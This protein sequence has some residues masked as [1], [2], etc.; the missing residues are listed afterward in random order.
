[1]CTLLPAL[2]SSSYTCM[3]ETT[4][5]V[6]KKFVLPVV[7]HN[8]AKPPLFNVS[9]RFSSL[10]V[11]TPAILHWK[12]CKLNQIFWPISE[13]DTVAATA[14]LIRSWLAQFMTE[15]HDKDARVS[16]LAC[17]EACQEESV[18]QKRIHRNDGLYFFYTK[19]G[20]FKIGCFKMFFENL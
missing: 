8:E 1:M 2:P 20:C 5:C 15:K 11:V 6:R 16:N 14:R 7:R 4:S 17:R 13:N 12:G 3:S 10:C 19:I 9:D 18:F